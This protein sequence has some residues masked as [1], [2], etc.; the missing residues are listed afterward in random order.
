MKLRD[1]GSKFSNQFLICCAVI[2]TRDRNLCYGYAGDTYANDYFRWLMLN[3]E[4]EFL[5]FAMILWT[6][7]RCLDCTRIGTLL[8]KFKNFSTFPEPL[9]ALYII[10]ETLSAIWEVLCPMQ[11]SGAGL[12]IISHNICGRNFY[13]CPWYLFLAQHTPHIVCCVRSRY[14]GQGQVPSS[15]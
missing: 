7:L 8:C 2:F 1:R 9:A 13:P 5:D 14:Q 12:V 10:T 4:T 11:I 15:L 3:F 6:Y